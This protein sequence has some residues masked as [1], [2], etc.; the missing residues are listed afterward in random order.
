M[1]FR[2]ASEQLDSGQISQE[3]IT[4]Q[5]LNLPCIYGIFK[6]QSKI[7]CLEVNNKQTNGEI[8]V[9]LLYSNLK[10]AVEAATEFQIPNNWYIAQ[11]SVIEDALKACSELD[12]DAV[13]FDSIPNKDTLSGLVIDKDSLKQLIWLSLSTK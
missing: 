13:A 5:I 8:T 1:D 10:I 11:W 7:F 12:V 9:A 3:E 2:T 6:D 4:R